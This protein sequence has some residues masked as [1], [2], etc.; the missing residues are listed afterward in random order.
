MSSKRKESCTMKGKEIKTPS[1]MLSIN[2]Q[3]ENGMRGLTVAK[4][5]A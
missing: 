2:N 1:M 5:S 4:A 3:L